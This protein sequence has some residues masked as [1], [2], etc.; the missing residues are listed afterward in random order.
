[1]KHGHI[2]GAALAGAVIMA[3]CSDQ[4]NAPSSTIQARRSVSTNWPNEPAALTPVTDYAFDDAIPSGNGQPLSGGWQINNPGGLATQITNDAEAPLSPP[5]V[6]QW[7]YPVGFHGGSPPALMYFDPPSYS[8]EVYLGLWWKASS[9]F[10]ENDAATTELLTVTTATPGNDVVMEMHQIDAAPTYAI[11]V[12]TQLG[13]MDTRLQPNV[14]TTSVPT[15]QWH[16]TEWYLK[17][18][19]SSTSADGI[20]K[21]WVDG[22]L[23]GDYETL[24]LPADAGFGEMQL[25]PSWDG[26]LTKTEQDFVWFDHIHISENTGTPS[27]VWPNEPAG[28]TLISDEPWNSLTENGWTVANNGAGNVTIAQDA[29]A[30][31]S[32]N[33]VAQFQYPTGFVDGSGPGETYIDFAQTHRVYVGLWW[34]P[35]A[36]WQGDSSNVNK[37]EYI[38]STSGNGSITLIMYGPPGGPYEL[39]VFPQFTGKSLD[40][41]LTPNVNDDSVALGV[42]HRVEWLV[43]YSGTS[44]HIQWWMDGRLQGDW[45]DDPPPAGPLIEYQLNPVWGGNWPDTKRETDYYWFDHTHLSTN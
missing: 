34:K 28:Y 25:R 2:L 12:V 20:I 5:N 31:L 33:N 43:D 14:T 27:A 3:A 32:P 8:K 13:G 42:W 7:S 38:Q 6:G 29:T 40:R 16:R 26:T 22:I 15:G 11:H 23:Q 45:S 10:E 4:P 9:P 41:W 44:G 35:S 1:M 19:T 37:I 17:Y 24:N 18:S 39:R 30:P 21:W 36:P